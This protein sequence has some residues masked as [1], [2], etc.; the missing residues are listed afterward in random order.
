[1]TLS[2]KAIRMKTHIHS[3]Q[4]LHTKKTMYKHPLLGGIKPQH[5]KAL[6]N[7][8]GERLWTQGVSGD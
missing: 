5:D 6:S 1:M 4:N 3:K 2:F 8:V 7:A